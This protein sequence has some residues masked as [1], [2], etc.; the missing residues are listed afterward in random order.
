MTEW[1][2]K[3]IIQSVKQGGYV[4]FLFDLFGKKNYNFR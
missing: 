2:D 3:S 1:L 4:K